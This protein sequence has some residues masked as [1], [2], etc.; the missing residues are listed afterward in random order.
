VEH[1]TRSAFGHGCSS[2]HQPSDPITNPSS[3]IAKNRLKEMG[4]KWRAWAEWSAAVIGPCSAPS[5][6]APWRP[7]PE[8]A[9]AVRAL[10]P[11]AQ[12]PPPPLPASRHEAGRGRGGGAWRSRLAFAPG[13]RAC[14]PQPQ[15]RRELHAGLL[16]VARLGGSD[17]SRCVSSFRG[18]RFA[19]AAR[20]VVFAALG[21]CRAASRAALTRAAALVEA[22]LCRRRPAGRASGPHSLVR[23]WR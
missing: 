10:P 20:R 14:H 4:K 19:L 8:A 15:C 23:R 22:A 9:D 12:R 2:F 5:A 7:A 18:C 11:A 1:L 3:N 17:P 6:G 13:V 21:A 16:S